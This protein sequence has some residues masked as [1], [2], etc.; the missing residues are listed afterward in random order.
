[1]SRKLLLL[2]TILA[3][4]PGATRAQEPC[5]T[6]RPG[7]PPAVSCWGIPS[8]TNFDI[9]YYVGGGCRGCGEA[10]RSD[11]GTWGWDSK[12]ILPSRAVVL[13]W[14]HCLRYQGGSGA[15]RTVGNNRESQSTP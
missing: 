9:G 5:T 14:C 2:V 3:F 12:S 13:S 10:R 4:C 6:C 1:M 7:G 8:N 11:E 15:Y